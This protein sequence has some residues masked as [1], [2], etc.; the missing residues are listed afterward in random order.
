MAQAGKG[1]HSIS[2][3]TC[4]D[5]DGGRFDKPC[6]ANVGQKAGKMLFSVKKHL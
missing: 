5:Y 2:Q 3:E 6:D 4:T 1:R